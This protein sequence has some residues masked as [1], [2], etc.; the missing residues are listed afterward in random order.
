MVRNK[1]SISSFS[2]PPMYKKSLY[3][4][5]FSGANLEISYDSC[6]D[7]YYCCCCYIF[8]SKNMKEKNI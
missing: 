5:I 6:L 3:R 8:Q 4:E 1:I 2:T 7:Y